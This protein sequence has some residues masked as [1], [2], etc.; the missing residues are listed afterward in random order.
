[1]EW[2]SAQQFFL[3]GGYWGYVWGAYGVGLVLM[4]GEIV[5]L[6]RRHRLLLR[7][8][9]TRVTEVGFEKMS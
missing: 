5:L 8:R 4:V 7:E 2:Q 9:T 3:M 1:M 6:A